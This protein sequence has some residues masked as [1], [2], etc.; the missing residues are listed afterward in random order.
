[1][2]GQ[3]RW[4]PGGRI[5]ALVLLTTVVWAG[6]ASAVP[7]T[8]EGTVQQQTEDPLR[9][10]RSLHQDG[11]YD[12]AAQQLQQQLDRGL[13]PR[14][15]E[16]A[17]WLLARTLEAA[18]RTG[19]AAEAYMEYTRR[20]G[21]AARAP[22]A[23]LKAGELFL[24]GGDPSAAADAYRGFISLFGTS[25]QRPRAELGLTETLLRTG[26]YAE[27]LDRVVEARRTFA[28][29]PL[30]VRFRLLE[31]RARR[32][33]GEDEDALSLA[34]EALERAEDP[35][36]K[37]EASV[38][39]ARLYAELDQPEE[40]VRSARSA[41]ESGPP[42][43]QQAE[44]RVLLGEA[45]VAADRPQE[46]LSE[47]RTAL[48]GGRGRTRTEAALWLGRAHAAIG[49]PDS[50][51]AAYEA[52]LAGMEGERAA[53]TA[54]E[55]AASA[56]SSGQAEKALVLASRG[57]R[58]AH[59]SSRRTEA[60]LTAAA[61][62]RGLDRSAEAAER[63]RILL[64]SEEMDAGDRYRAAMELGAIYE[65]DYGDTEQAGSY[66][67]LASSLAGRGERWAR[68]LRGG[69][70]TLASRG[71]Y[72]EAIRELQPVADAGGAMHAEAEEQIDYW[73][74][75]RA[76]DLRSGLRSL[77]EALLAL[78]SGDAEGRQEALLGVA[79]ANA[80]ALKDFEAAVAAYDRYLA[81]AEE[82][83]RA[84]RAHLE[85][86][87]AL[88]ALAVIA[89]SEG[90]GEV[91][92]YRDRAAASY[93]AAVRGG[94]ESPAAEEA[95]IA[96]IELELD[97]LEDQPV[98][99]YQAMRDRYRAFLDTFTGSRRL[100]EVLLR[101][102]RANEGLG[103]H[104]DPSYYG[105]AASAY[106]LLLE[107]RKPREIQARARAG[108]G[109]SL[110]RSGSYEE[111]AGVMD[112]ALDSL[113]PEL[114]EERPRLLYMAGDALMRAGRPEAASDRFQQLQVRYPESPWTAR[115]SEATGDLFLE[116]GEARR[117]VTA[118]RRF[119]QRAGPEDRAR[120][121]LKL[122]SALAGAGERDE[123]AGLA[124]EAASDSLASTDIVRQA[125]ALR[126]RLARQ[127]GTAGEAVSA[128]DRLWDI[129]PGSEEAREIAPA[130]G[131]LLS[132]AGRMDRAE[133]V[134]GSIAARAEGDSLRARAEAEMVYLAW[135]RN[136][137][138]TARQRQEA[139]EETWR[140]TEGVLSTYRPLFW[141]V[142]GQLWMQRQE[143]RRAERVFEEILG[144]AEESR[145]A[146]IAL[147]GLGEV[148]ARQEETE[149][150]IERFQE[151]VERFPERPEAV[152]ARFQLAQL[153]YLNAEYER[154]VPH[155]RE[156]ASS[157][158]PELAEAA[159]F[160]LVETLER[161][162]AWDAAQQE[163][164]T[165]LERFPD[166]EDVFEMKMR[167][168][169]LYREGGQL[170]R[171]AEYF[172][173]LRA[174]DGEAEARLRFQLAETLYG[175][176]DYEQAVL[177]YLKVAYLNEDQFL[178]AVTARLRAADSYAHLGQRDRAVSMYRDI[179]ERYGADSDYGR[180]AREHLDNVQA[181]RM[182][183]A[184]PPPPQGRGDRGGSSSE[185]DSLDRPQ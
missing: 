67:R 172:R 5:A 139:F 38:L 85:K 158:D 117:A 57:A 31:A 53:L 164:L 52:A 157:A 95:Q 123:A 145:Y 30:E 181:G 185:G 177:E 110:Y 168:G 1:M 119:A 180:T 55:A 88:E 135:A 152:R 125:L 54:L 174:P 124:E 73:R 184:L 128:W 137:V 33:L 148:R 25:D 68:A 24:G 61:I 134:W 176:S 81:S 22:Q 170:S 39:I 161:M 42:E 80:G 103:E 113:P 109:R 36:L 153:A 104:A 101:I 6:Q 121:R 98:L 92:S 141:A 90:T 29:H 74:R 70:R 87:R 151:L 155:Y 12:L 2:N 162:R 82:G 71:L 108:L 178:F 156:V 86:G 62:L 59:S 126:G 10:A 21:S 132:E 47:L 35:G 18:G 83:G 7:S 127:A 9:F 11:L 143:W 27:A 43:E 89:A 13:P 105:E 165:Y 106:R 111:A 160:N 96:L 66:Y 169:R 102:A 84:A 26:A 107:G 4:I 120:A 166:S 183:G 175:M 50:A 45:L 97:G 149:E 16:E 114:E 136:Q 99:Y 130:Y 23:W 142:E 144:E 19:A 79:R 20:H 69:A 51:L 17:R 147:Y 75:Y 167:L 14:Q 93:Q 116:R 133:E 150:A 115:S 15:A 64:D 94:G 182:P 159:Q 28:F 48:S 78:A 76:V 163:A 131:E 65:E 3:T 154:A 58:E 77:Q 112:R 56:R 118:Y 100:N 49:E 46:A 129:A 122:A 40:A 140:G 44:L 179:I 63:L 32:G 41:L 171:A 37:T 34:L 146:P 138:E 72:S 91:S 60:T 8:A 173:S